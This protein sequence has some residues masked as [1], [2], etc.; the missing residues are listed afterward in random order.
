[1]CIEGSEEN[2]RTTATAHK[3]GA[4]LDHKPHKAAAER[5]RGGSRTECAVGRTR[6]APLPRF[7]AAPLRSQSPRTLTDTRR[8][9]AGPAR[10][11]SRPEAPKVEAT[12]CWEQPGE[13]GS[14]KRSLP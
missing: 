3:E 12:A 9:G 11:N 7:P 13:P 8:A 1:M 5:R 10:R 2:S 6:L 4:A 14:V